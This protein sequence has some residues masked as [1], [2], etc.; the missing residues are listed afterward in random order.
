MIQDFVFVLQVDDWPWVRF[1]SSGRSGWSECGERHSLVADD[2]LRVVD[3][4]DIV[5]HG[6]RI[7][8]TFT[9]GEI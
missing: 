3:P 2:V 5:L 6:S 8:Y 9:D 1:F 4:L 7:Y